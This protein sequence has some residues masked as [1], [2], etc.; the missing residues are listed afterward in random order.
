MS[1]YSMINEKSARRLTKKE[2]IE[3]YNN[4]VEEI[5]SLQERKQILSD[6]NDMLWEAYDEITW[7]MHE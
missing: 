4:A 5:W 2:L 1:E 6:E 3:M 7:G